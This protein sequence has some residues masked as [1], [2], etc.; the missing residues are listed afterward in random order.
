MREV[1]CAVLVDTAVS[2][3]SFNLARTDDS[4]EVGGS[5]WCDRI[6][7]CPAL[8]CREVMSRPKYRF[9]MHR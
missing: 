2:M 7:I 1:M 8:G 4:P 9:V 6:G 5:L 3:A